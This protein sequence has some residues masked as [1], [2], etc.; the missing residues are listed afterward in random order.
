MREFIDLEQ[1]SSLVSKGEDSKNQFKEDIRNVDSLAAEMAAF[2]NSRG[3]IIYIGVS[4]DGHLKGLLR[5]DVDRINQL[6]SNAA[7]QYV[8]NPIAVTTENVPVGGDRIVIVLI[9]SEGIEK[10]YFDHQGIIW[11]KSGADKRRINS[12]EELRRLFQTVDLLHADE[13]PTRAG[14]DELNLPLLSDFLEG[15]FQELVPPA[16]IEQIRLLQNMNLASEDRLNLAGLLFF[17]KNP[18]KFKPA[19][20]IKAVAFSGTDISDSYF[21]SEDFSGVLQE[22]YKGALAFIMRNVRKVQKDQSVNTVGIP[23]I[24]QIVFEEI[25]VNSLIHRDYFLNGPIKVFVFSDRF[26]IISPGSLP[27]HLTVEKIRAGN[28]VQRNPI[29]ASY[30]AKGL[31]PYRGLGTGIR[32]AVKDWPDIQFVDDREGCSF[33]VIVKKSDA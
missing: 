17:G 5:Q 20:V 10:P 8:K 11:L 21:D 7:S 12:K 30:A 28:S 6:I 25:L 24:P 15:K 14:I 1:L 22:M 33:T 19:F 4:D 29:L 16:E 31:L 9:I 32:R 2:S 23:E 13:A 18:Q 3:G 27:N 26:E